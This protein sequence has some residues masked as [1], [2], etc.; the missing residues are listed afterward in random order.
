MNHLVNTTLA[1]VQ[2]RYLHP[3]LRQ[4]IPG[5]AAL[6]EIGQMMD[7]DVDAMLAYTTKHVHVLAAWRWLTSRQVAPGVFDI[8]YYSAEFCDRLLLELQD[9][10]FARNEMEDVNFQIEELVLGNELPDL[11]ETCETLFA[12]AMQPVLALLFSQDDS[13][14]TSI[15]AAKYNPEEVSHGNWHFD[16]DSDHT[17]VVSLNPNDFKG[18]GTELRTGPFTV[19]YIPPLPKGHALLFM[20]RTTLHRGLYVEEGDRMLLVHWT[21]A[22]GHKYYNETEH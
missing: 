16:Q 9:K 21:V 20:G 2:A 5:I 7:W 14:L 6:A 10:E 19:Q 3:A 11:F 18:G 15:Q 8:P 22:S 4:H 17:V 13:D 12:V 1:D